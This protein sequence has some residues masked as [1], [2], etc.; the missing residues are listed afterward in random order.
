MCTGYATIKAVMHPLHQPHPHPRR[1]THV[2][3]TLSLRGLSWVCPQVLSGDR[4]YLFDPQGSVLTDAGVA[5]GNGPR[6]T[7]ADGVGRGYRFVDSDLTSRF[8][9]Q[10]EPFSALPFG[11]KGAS[12]YGNTIIRM[13]MR[14]SPSRLSRSTPGLSCPAL[15]SPAALGLQGLPMSPVEGDEMRPRMWA[16][17]WLNSAALFGRCCAGVAACS[18]WVLPWCVCWR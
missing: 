5:V 9:H 4:L 14:R 7:A 6:P 10:F 18:N 11:F 13:P 1:H 16:P 3:Y 8:P 17:D 2:S 12:Y 15:C